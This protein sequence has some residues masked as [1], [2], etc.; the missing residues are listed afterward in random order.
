MN[1]SEV[2]FYGGTALMVLSVLGALC[3]IV[4]LRVSR[5]H[6][7]EKLNAEYGEDPRR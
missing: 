1:I 7:R 2:L 4:I 6:L 3:A 5:K